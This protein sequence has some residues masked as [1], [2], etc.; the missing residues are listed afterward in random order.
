MGCH[1]AVYKLTK[2]CRRGKELPYYDFVR[3]YGYPENNRHTS[4][5]SL[6]VF[7]R[8]YSPDLIGKWVRIHLEIDGRLQECQ[9][10][11][12]SDGKCYAVL[13]THHGYYPNQLVR[14]LDD[15]HDVIDIVIKELRRIVEKHG[16]VVI[17][18]G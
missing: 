18:I 17:T 16:N 14:V 11:V 12:G 13:P 15:C 6:E 3:I 5:E 8:S 9:A 1:V 7:L 4:V 2:N 10:S